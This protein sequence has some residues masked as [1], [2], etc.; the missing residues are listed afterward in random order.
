ML[1]ITFK[2][3]RHGPLESTRYI[4]VETIRIRKT[5]YPVLPDMILYDYDYDR[6]D[7]VDFV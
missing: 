4:R 3:F 5:G 2:F 6:Y 1:A 7:Y